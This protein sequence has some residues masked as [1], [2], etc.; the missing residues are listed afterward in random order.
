MI[1][2]IYARA[3]VLVALTLALA[4][5]SSGAPPRAEVQPPVMSQYKGW[6]I[7]ETPSR[8]G[9]LWRAEVRV[10]PP[11]VRP[12]GH[13][14]ISVSFS[15]ASTDRRAVEEAATAAARRYIDASLPVQQ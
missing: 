14:G 7:S 9:D 15:G 5:C 8:L 1:A 13:P 2:A 4:G 11:E 12:E 3:T 10:W 6:V